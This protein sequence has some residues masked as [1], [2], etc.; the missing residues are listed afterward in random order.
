MVLTMKLTSFAYNYYDGT[1]DRDQVFSN[2]FAEKT[3]K[4]KKIYLGNS[5]IML[6]QNRITP[7][8][9]IHGISF[10]TQKVC[11]HEIT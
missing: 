1:A 3:E 9:T 6:K 8:L 11:D 7:H 2:E 5:D 4:N 10:R